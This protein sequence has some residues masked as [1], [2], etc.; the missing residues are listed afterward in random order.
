ML[1][2]QNVYL[3]CLKVNWEIPGFV[4]FD[5]CVVCLW[6]EC[7]MLFKSEVFSISFSRV[8]KCIEWCSK[9]DRISRECFYEFNK[10]WISG[11]FFCWHGRYICLPD[12]FKA[13]WNLDQRLVLLPTLYSG[14]LSAKRKVG[15]KLWK[16]EAE[17]KTSPDFCLYFLLMIGKLTA[18]LT[19]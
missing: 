16:E 13:G 15:F 12:W 6:L 14:L 1:N 9:S 8:H 5:V 3:L 11:L 19:G 17:W 4:L 18:E 2:L 10:L 7:V